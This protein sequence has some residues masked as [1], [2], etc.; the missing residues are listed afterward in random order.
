[1]S[2]PDSVQFSSNPVEG[3]QAESELVIFRSELS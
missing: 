2:T 3:T 1:M